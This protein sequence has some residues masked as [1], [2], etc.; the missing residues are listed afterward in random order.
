MAAQGSA[1]VEAGASDVVG[2]RSAPLCRVS[3]QIR[4]L[5]ESD[6]LLISNPRRWV[7]FPIQHP[8]IWEAYKKHVASF[9]TAE[10]IDLSQDI[11]DWEHLNSDE[12]HFITHVLAFFAASD[13]IVLENLSSKFSTEVQVPEA[14]AFYGFQV[15]MENIHSET[16]S[17]LV[18]QFVRDPAQR[19][20]VFNAIETM[21]V[22]GEGRLGCAVDE[23]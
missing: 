4:E 22:A 7:M 10:E 21:P 20:N 17:L 6:P 5:E 3:Q 23:R 18:E 13:G 1:L 8:D 15:A 14:R 2:F 9:W 19:D 12:Q 16:Y 11:V